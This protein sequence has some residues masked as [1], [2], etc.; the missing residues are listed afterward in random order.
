MSEKYV[1]FIIHRPSPSLAPRKIQT[2]QNSLMHISSHALSLFL[3]YS[4]SV[5]LC[6]DDSLSLGFFLFLAAFAFV[7]RLLRA[8]D[9]RSLHSLTS[10][11]RLH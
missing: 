6:H 1:L 3:S 11:S 2:P 10:T 9:A 7:F 4:Y 5:T 8:L